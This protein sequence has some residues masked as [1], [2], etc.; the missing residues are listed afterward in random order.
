MDPDHLEELPLL[1]IVR[2]PDVAV[3]VLKPPRPEI[4]SALREPDS[5]SGLAV[6]LGQPRQRL[7][8]HV[9]ALEGA[10]LVRLVEE[11]RRRGCTERMMQATAGTIF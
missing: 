11:R 4:L 3:V 5:A 9:R 2:D 10:G 7:S 1:E 6:R 8:H